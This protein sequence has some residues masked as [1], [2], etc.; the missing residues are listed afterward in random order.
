MGWMSFSSHAY[1]MKSAP[2]SRLSTGATRRR[3]A[4]AC[5]DGLS[6]GFTVMP[7][8]L[9]NSW[10]IG[11]R[12]LNVAPTT[13]SSF[14][15]APATGIP[16]SAIAPIVIAPL[17]STSRRVVVMA[18]PPLSRV[19]D[20]PRRRGRPRSPAH[21]PEQRGEERH[22]PQGDGRGQGADRVERG[23]E[24]AVELRIDHEG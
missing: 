19:V 12:R 8:R 16:P 15:W 2:D 1:L 18:V 3:S 17:F 5:A 4:R 22:G 13:L 11:S 9:V 14:P 21:E 23:L 7:V 6:H 20:R 24:L 10:R